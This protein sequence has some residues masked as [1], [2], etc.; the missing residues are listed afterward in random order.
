MDSMRR[1]VGVTI[2]AALYL[3]V[4]ILG[5]V[6]HFRESL[7]APREGVWVELTEIL[8]ILCGV[9]LLCGRNWARWLAVA[10]MAF[11]VALS[12][13]HLSQ[14]AVHAV[15]CVLIAWVLFRRDAAQY[16]GGTRIEPA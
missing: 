8:A 9:Y 11:H 5:F 4:G 3:A 6:F 14:F 16:F 2:I 15:F 12:I 7:A 13:H 1:P 10:W